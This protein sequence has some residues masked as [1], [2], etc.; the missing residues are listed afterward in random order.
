[1]LTELRNALPNLGSEKASTT[2][3]ML[4][5]KD[6][7]DSLLIQIGELQDEV[8]VFR[9]SLLIGD[10][11]KGALEQMPRLKGAFDQ[12]PSLDRG[13]MFEN[14]RLKRENKSLK[15]RVKL[16]EHNTSEVG[17]A[18]LAPTFSISTVTF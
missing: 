9:Q 13:L 16:V 7:I 4:K 15:A 1:M 5:A 18:T 2:S 17:Y 10:S 6:Y 3:I 8:N 12:M 14:A 11:A